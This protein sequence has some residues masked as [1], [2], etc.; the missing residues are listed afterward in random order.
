M[1]HMCTHIP[2]DPKLVLAVE[3]SKQSYDEFYI[4]FTAG[5]RGR[6]TKLASLEGNVLVVPVDSEA[7]WGWVT[8][9]QFDETYEPVAGFLSKTDFTVCK[10]K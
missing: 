9:E 5:R 2:D 4:P 3:V 10:A 1:A 7:T 6:K 8:K